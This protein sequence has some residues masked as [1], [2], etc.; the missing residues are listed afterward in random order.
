LLTLGTMNAYYAGVA[1]LGA[2]LGRDGALPEWLARGSLA[3][4]VPRRSLAVVSALT[5]PSLIATGLFHLATQTLVSL[6]AGLIVAVYAIG[7]AAA[8]RLLPRRSKGRA[9]AMAALVAVV[10]LLAT[11][12]IYLIW[13][14]AVSLAAL[15]YLRL[16]S[17]RRAAPPVPTPS[18]AHES[19]AAA[20]RSPR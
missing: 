12:G 17:K 18:G 4:E 14:L 11:T 15:L 13:A 5:I 1:K 6:T 7:V 16:R 8:V 19:P 2:A 3:G 20:V 9:A 10:A